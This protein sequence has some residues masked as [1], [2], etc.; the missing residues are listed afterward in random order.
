[1]KATHNMG[2]KGFSLV[3]ILVVVAT[4]AILGSM[5]YVAVTRTT[6]TAKGHKLLSD[7]ATVNRAVQM[8]LAN[9]GNLTSVTGTNVIT[10]LKTRVADAAAAQRIGLNSSFLDARIIPLMQN[11][12]EAGT[13]QLRAVWNSSANRFDVTSSGSAGIR[14]FVFDEDLAAAA[15]VADA[16]STTKEATAS[17]WIWDHASTS[18]TATA[19]GATPPT[20]IL[21]TAIASAIGQGFTGGFWEVNDPNGQVDVGYVFREAGYSS[22]LALVSLEGMGPENFDLTTTAG[23]TAFMTE[24]VRRAAQQDRAQVIID[25]SASTAGN[26]AQSYFFRPGDTVVAVMIPNASFDTAYSQLQSGTTNAQ[27]FPLTSL[28]LGTN[29]APFYTGQIASLGN[30]G[31][32]IEDQAGGGDRDYDDLVFTAQGLA[33][34]QGASFNEIDPNTY[35]PDRYA[36]L[37]KN[38]WNN[39]YNGGPSLQQSLINAGIIGQ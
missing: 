12:N 5:G 21:T 35:Y 24:L 27:T 25:A 22:R 31:Y 39:P 3:E 19:T 17:G 11:Q 4:M 29:Q 33:Q 26:F 8:Y 10:R 15:S 18:P 23:R 2:S 30:N 28:N 13:S 14:E 36:Q 9:G 20:G 37:N 7:V 38:Y 6:A 1:M 16:R 34:S 32:A